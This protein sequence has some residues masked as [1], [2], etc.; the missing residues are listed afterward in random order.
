MKARVAFTIEGRSES[1]LPEMVI[2]CADLHNLDIVDCTRWAERG[3]QS[4]VDDDSDDDEMPDM[5]GGAPSLGKYNSVPA[6]G[7]SNGSPAGGSSG[8]A[9]PG[10][11]RRFITR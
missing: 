7:S 6:M 9:S 5:P 10:S 4:V 8:G 2:G 1:Q 3:S 11:G